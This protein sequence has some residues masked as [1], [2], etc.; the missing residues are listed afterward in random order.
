MAGIEA[1]R[2]KDGLLEWR[3]AGYPLEHSQGHVKL[4]WQ[5]QRQLSSTSSFRQRKG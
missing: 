2:I 4:R 1:R 3:R 5:N